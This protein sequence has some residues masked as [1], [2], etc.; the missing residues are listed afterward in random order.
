M[1]STYGAMKFE[2]HR[3]CLRPAAP[4][5]CDLKSG[6]VLVGACTIWKI[7]QDWVWTS[8]SRSNPTPAHWRCCSLY[9]IYPITSANELPTIDSTGFVDVWFWKCLKDWILIIFDGIPCKNYCTCFWMY[10]RKAVLDH[11]PISM[12]EKIGTLAR[13]MSITAPDQMERVLIFKKKT[14]SFVLP[15]ATT[16]SQMRSAIISEVMLMSLFLWQARDTDESVVVSLYERIHR[17]PD[18][19]GA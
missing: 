2:M 18:F 4:S 13:Y 16:P 7:R 1:C 14:P 19:G 12:I 6:L 9:Q 17:Q 3:V 5:I 11:C 15:M 10:F 8:F